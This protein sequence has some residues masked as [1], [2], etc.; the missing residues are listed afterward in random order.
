MVKKNKGLPEESDLV[1][2]N[3]T[4][5]YP[6]CVFANLDEYENKQGMIHIS[7]ISPGRI[8]NIQD[9]VK[10]G[11]KIICKVLSINQERGH[12]D[13]SLRRVSEGQKR[14]KAEEIKRQQKAE[15]II[16]FVADKLKTDKQEF[17]D[18]VE[19]K[20]L[21]EYD[22]LHDAFE[23]F[24]VDDTVL[25]KLKFEPKIYE[26]LAETIRQRIKPPEV[27]IEGEVRMRSYGPEGVDL[28]KK[29]L[30]DGAKTDE[31]VIIRYKG[32]GTYS[33]SVTYDN[34]KDAERIMKTA[35]DLMEEESNK[36]KC[37]FSFQRLEKKQSKKAAA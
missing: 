32:G 3:V 26:L 20:V 27:S 14:E 25:K 29:I 8:R 33:I 15:K 31:V 21:T 1:L 6:H 10:I 19:S 5:I 17:Y 37:E 16:E 22:T 13:L 9:Y 2:C 11:K 36:S 23:D 28:I 34:Y 30:V 18:V 12:I 35:V 7:E 24:I 4:K